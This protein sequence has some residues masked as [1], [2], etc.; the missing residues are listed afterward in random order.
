MTPADPLTKKSI[1]LAS[2]AFSQGTEVLLRQGT[3][4]FAACLSREADAIASSRLAAF[5]EEEIGGHDFNEGGQQALENALDSLRLK[6]AGDKL[7]QCASPS[8]LYVALLADSC[9][10]T[11]IQLYPHQLLGVSW[12][13]AQEKSKYKGGLLADEM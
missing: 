2:K 4:L 13:L 5:F 11:N 10:S 6:Q 12:M 9:G 1:V 8:K 7:P 3:L